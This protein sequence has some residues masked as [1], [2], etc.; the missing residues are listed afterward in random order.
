M[1]IIYSLTPKLRI[2]LKEPL[3]TLIRG[4][5]IETMNRL[6][7]LIKEENPP[8]VISVGDTVSRN[9]EKIQVHPKLSIIDNFAMRKVIQPVTLVAD[10]TLRVRNPQA[11]ITEEAITAVQNS[12]KNDG[13]TN[14]IVEGEEDL[15]TLIAILYAPENTLVVYGQ[16]YEGIVVVKATS[17]K[18]EEVARIL[19]AMETVRK[20]K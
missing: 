11:T 10:K 9:L 15:L 20:A 5:F 2:K 6:K 13:S 4:S 16:P 19:K 18:K 12:L 17:T 14:I 7:V 1:D 8:C 3:G